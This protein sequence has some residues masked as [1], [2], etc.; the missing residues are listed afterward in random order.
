MKHSL[1]DLKYR[2]LSGVIRI[3]T[4]STHHLIEI[5]GDPDLILHARRVN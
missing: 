3:K 5:S 1:S 4:H 2:W